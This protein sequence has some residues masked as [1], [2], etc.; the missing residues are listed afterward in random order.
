MVRTDTSSSTASCPAVIWPRA[1]SN[2]MIETSRLARISLTLDVRET[3]LASGDVDNR[4]IPP[5]GGPN[6][7]QRAHAQAISHHDL[8]GRDRTRYPES[9]LGHPASAG[10]S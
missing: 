2:K 8:R 6:R 7:D 3:C 9:R 4:E 5:R 1:C 10:A